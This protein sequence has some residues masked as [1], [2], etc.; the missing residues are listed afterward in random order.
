MNLHTYRQMRKEIDDLE[1]EIAELER[2]N[3]QTSNRFAMF[4]FLLGC[5]FMF[6]LLMIAR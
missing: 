4:Y 2:E 6:T 1:R 5:L 3:D